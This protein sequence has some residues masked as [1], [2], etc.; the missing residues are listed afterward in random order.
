MQGKYNFIKLQKV[1]IRDFSLYSKKGKLYEV[2]E[3]INEGVFCLAG[4]NGLGKTTFLNA[5]NYGLT[6]I[7]LEPNKEVYSPTE[8]VRSNHLYTERYFTGRVTK[9]DEK[10]AEIEILFAVND[11]FFRIIRGFFEREELRLLEIYSR[12]NGKQI[13]HFSK[14]DKSPTQLNASYQKLL[15]DEIG[16]ADFDYFIFYQLSIVSDS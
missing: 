12:N 16:F 5:I 2:E 14:K 10:S 7:V 4:A 1:M 13:S 15:S 6:G 8:I 3:T 11:K 9:K